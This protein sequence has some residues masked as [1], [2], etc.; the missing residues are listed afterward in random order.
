[1]D[2]LSTAERLAER[3]RVIEN[4]PCC[5]ELS[6]LLH[7]RMRSEAERHATSAGLLSGDSDLSL[8][9]IDLRRDEALRSPDPDIEVGILF[10]SWDERV[11]YRELRPFKRLHYPLTVQGEAVAPP[12]YVSVGFG[13]YVSGPHSRIREDSITLI[14]DRSEIA[15]EEMN[16]ASND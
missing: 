8:L 15:P 3:M 4:T 12:A 10:Y 14:W 16:S 1:M 11:S 13:D 9:G 5:I 7:A 2:N 6:P